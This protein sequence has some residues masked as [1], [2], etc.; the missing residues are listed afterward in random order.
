MAGGYR[1]LLENGAAAEDIFWQVSG[2]IKIG[3]KAHME[4]TIL[5]YS[6]VTFI[7]GSTLN[8]RIYAQTAVALQMAIIACPHRRWHLF[9]RLNRLPKGQT[10]KLT[11]HCNLQS[12]AGGRSINNIQPKYAF[13]Y[14][15]LQ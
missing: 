13:S 10:Y 1:V 14:L 2:Y 12:T 3:A 15:A 8:G 9:C 11:A 7:T 6:S 4:G 5:T